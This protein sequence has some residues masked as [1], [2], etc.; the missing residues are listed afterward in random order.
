[1]CPGKIFPRKFGFTRHTAS[2]HQQQRIACVFQD[3]NKNFCVYIKDICCMLQG[4]QI[5]RFFLSLIGHIHDET[6]FRTNTSSKHRQGNFR[7]FRGEKIG[8]QMLCLPKGL[9]NAVQT[10]SAC[11]DPYVERHN[12]AYQTNKRNTS[13]SAPRC[14]TIVL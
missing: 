9:F 2:V 11:C 14:F 7:G 6:T 4:F 1:M 3:C 12:K 5:A 8:S 13:P 10:S